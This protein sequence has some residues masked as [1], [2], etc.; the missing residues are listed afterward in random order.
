MLLNRFRDGTVKISEMINQGAGKDVDSDQA[1][2]L[3]FSEAT[4]EAAQGGDL[5]A[6]E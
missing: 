1:K 6:G 2:P 4:Q 3:G 5:G